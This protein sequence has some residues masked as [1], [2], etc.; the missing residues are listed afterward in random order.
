MTIPS[1]REAKA[2]DIPAMARIRAAEWESEEYWIQR[3]RAYLSGDLDPK[4]ALKTRVIYVCC[5]GDS[6]IGFVAG[7]VTTRHLCQGELQWINVI[8]ERR[9]SGVASALLRLLAEWFIARN[10]LRICVDV[11]PSNEVGRRFYAKHRAE[12]LKPHWM[13]WKDIRL[14]LEGNSR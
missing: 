6:V 5:E 7:H 8:P 3:I 9:G 11:E 2:A 4:W 12:D 10:A 14:V 1:F 13:V